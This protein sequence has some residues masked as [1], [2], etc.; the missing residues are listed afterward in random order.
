[1]HLQ[2][3]HFVMA[4]LALPAGA[5]AHHGW[6]RFDLERPW[7]LAGVL[8]QVR[9]ANPHAELLLRVEQGLQVPADLPGRALPRQT[10]PVD[11]ASL[12][13][14][15]RVP[16][17]AGGDWTVE[18]APLTRLQAWGLE[19]LVA[20]AR[21]ELIGFTQRGAAERMLRAEFL[22]VGARAIGLRSSPA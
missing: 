4:S 13:Q 22:F 15:A 9:W 1:M 18:L 7:Y 2:R 20:G 6:S 3:R 17:G 19:P 11:G 10:A 21:V 5:W 12:L 14:R 16:E 8:Q